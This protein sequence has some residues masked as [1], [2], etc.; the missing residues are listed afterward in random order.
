[1][2]PHEKGS[3]KAPARPI[4]DVYFSREAGPPD[5][6]EL[7]GPP[8]LAVPVDALLPE[9]D[10]LVV[11]STF[12]P[13][14]LVRDAVD[15]DLFDGLLLFRPPSLAVPVDALLPEG[16]VAPGA[17]SLRV[18]PSLARFDGFEL[19]GPPSLAVPVEALLP[20]G[21]S[22]RL[23]P[24]AAKIDADASDMQQSAAAMVVR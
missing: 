8:S 17:L 14:P 9:G 12:D 21:V 3:R 18:G 19:F 10:G 4:V 20:E 11:V 23:M 13:A 2:R 5:G 15:P 6:F 7:F 1:M 22:E 16:G 24:S